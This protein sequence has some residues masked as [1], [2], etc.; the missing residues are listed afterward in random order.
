ME[1]YGRE[2]CHVFL[3]KD[4]FQCGLDNIS[5]HLQKRKL[6]LEKNAEI[7]LWDYKK[8]IKRVRDAQDK[9]TKDIEALKVFIKKTTKSLTQKNKDMDAQ[10]KALEEAEQTLLNRLAFHDAVSNWLFPDDEG[11]LAISR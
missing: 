7:R 6:L 8:H 11:N 4:W 5:Q 3:D 2:K 10:R 9:F 1:G